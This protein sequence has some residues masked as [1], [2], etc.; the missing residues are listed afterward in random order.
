[1]VIEVSPSK[2][3]NQDKHHLIE[4]IDYHL[5][6]VDVEVRHL[7]HLRMSGHVW[8]HRASAVQPLILR[9]IVCPSSCVVLLSQ[10]QGNES[11]VHQCLN[12]GLAALVSFEI[13][14]IKHGKLRTLRYVGQTDTNRL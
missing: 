6:V 4:T 2:P 1:M 9:V 8:T 13:E 11:V 12:G 5:L 14:N 7:H 3:L 10:V